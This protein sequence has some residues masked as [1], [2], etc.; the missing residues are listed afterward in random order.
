[1]MIDDCADSSEKDDSSLLDA[2]E[3]SLPGMVLGGRMCSDVH[4]TWYHGACS[5]NV[6]DSGGFSL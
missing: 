4:D 5:V 2:S 6:I 1:M 3:D